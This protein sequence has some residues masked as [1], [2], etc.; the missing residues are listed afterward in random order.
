MKIYLSKTDENGDKKL[1]IFICVYILSSS[2]NIAVKTI[3]PV[4]GVAWNIISRSF[5]GLIILA[6]I[7]AL[8]V[9][10]YRAKNSLVLCEGGFLFLYILSFL[11]G[12]ADRALLS[13]T[14][15]WTLA[16]CIPIGIAGVAVY[17][18]SILFDYLRICSFIEFPILYIALLSMRTLGSYSMSVSYALILPILF[19]FYSYF[20]H[21]NY[22]AFIIGVVGVVL[23][24]VFGAR[25]PFFCIAT[26]VFIK[27]FTEKGSMKIV[28]LRVLLVFLM[29]ILLIK[30]DLLLKQIQIFLIG[31]GISSYALQR[32]IN[33]QILETAGRD[34]LWRYYTELVKKRPLIGYG[35]QGGWI[36]SGNGPHNMLLEFVL[37]FG[38]VI[39]GF[40]SVYSVYLYIKSIINRRGRLGELVFILASYNLTMYLVSGNWLEK[41]LFFLFVALSMVKCRMDEVIQ[42]S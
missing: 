2:L 22:I 6:L 25:G 39:G 23:I 20:E 17:N 14:A 5:Q 42:G 13:G 21:H 27:L 30:W 33:G 19:L 4:S 18:K 40:I 35:L 24:I 37:A 7:V 10:L 16:V 15:F 9:I 11:M 12:Q 34:E 38:V 41:P 1:S 26:Y 28:S 3:L 32:L 36:A 29:A 8:P 31:N